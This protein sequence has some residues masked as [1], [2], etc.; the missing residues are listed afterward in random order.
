MGIIVPEL[1]APNG[2]VLSNAYVSYKNACIQTLPRRGQDRALWATASVYRNIS[3]H[4]APVFQFDITLTNPDLS[5]GPFI[6]MY[7]ALNEMFPTGIVCQE[8]EDPEVD[9]LQSPFL[10]R[11]S[12]T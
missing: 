3:M 4:E 8:P 12:P 5:R 9:P 1:V 2:E 11:E 7:A 6:N 10:Q